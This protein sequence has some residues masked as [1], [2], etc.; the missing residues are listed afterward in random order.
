MAAIPILDIA[1]K[2]FLRRKEYLSVKEIAA[3]TSLSE[4]HIRR[5]CAD[6]SLAVS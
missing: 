6:G 5:L 3:E 4:R 1:E 2:L